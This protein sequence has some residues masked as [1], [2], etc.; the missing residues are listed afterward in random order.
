MSW[1]NFWL[2][3]DQNHIAWQSR[4]L[5]PLS[6]WVCRTAR[7]RLK[8][9]E[10]H[11]PAKTSQAKVIVVGN[12]VVGGSGK[13]PFILWLAEK[14]KQAG[15]RCGIV[16]RGYGGQSKIWPQS[17]TADSDPNLVGDEP[18]VLAKKLQVPVVVSP[19]RAEAVA[20]L[21][22]MVKDSGEHLDVIISDDGLQHFAMA[23]DIE[24]AMFDGERGL[25]NGLCMPSGPLRE[26]KRRLKR[27]DFVVS[28][29]TLR[30]PLAIAD[31]IEV[32]RLEPVCFRSVKSPDKTLPIDAFK[33]KAVHAIAGI[34]NPQRFKRTLK[35][36]GAIPELKPF[37]D[38]QAYQPKDFD[39]LKQQSESIPLLMTE[40]DAVK[41][42]AF[43]EDDW[44]YL[45]VQ[46]QCNDAFAKRLI[47]KLEKV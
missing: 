28:N 4:L 38:H 8:A 27:V 44:W 39:W 3:A 26:P 10:A 22:E 12:L 9:F 43:A 45:E 17:V 14:L 42:Q 47:A 2:K 13:T 20:Y 37:A 23:R 33:N 24:V 29:G 36:L 15:F 25:G 30:Y 21:E 1:P 7:N 46:P 31:N 16:S 6:W 11:P 34:G 19:K 18:V 40:K 32:M 41:C 35:R 5:M